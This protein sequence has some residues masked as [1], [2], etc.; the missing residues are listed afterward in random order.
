MK[1]K[2]SKHNETRSAG[3]AATAIPQMCSTP[4][5]KDSHPSNV[6][7]SIQQGRR[8]SAEEAEDDAVHG[9][10]LQL[11]PLPRRVPAHS[12]CAP[13]EL[14]PLSNHRPEQQSTVNSS[15]PVVKGPTPCHWLPGFPCK[16]E[17]LQQGKKRAVRR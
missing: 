9:L 4:S 12:T 10:H 16:P 2:N 13:Q 6:L 14:V 7:D 15:P 8:V 5:N 17:A 1:R 3:T 11:Q